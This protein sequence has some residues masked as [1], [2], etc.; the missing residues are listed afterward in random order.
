MEIL[1]ILVLIIFNG[2]FSMS[3]IALVSSRKS[4]LEAQAKNGDHQAQEALQLASSPNRFLSTVQIG[5][6]PH[7]YPDGS[8]QWG[9]PYK[10]Y[11]N[12]Y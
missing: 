1:I 9:C 4:K 8:V 11:S 2:V 6:T 3:E 10:K 5:I 7:W 12:F